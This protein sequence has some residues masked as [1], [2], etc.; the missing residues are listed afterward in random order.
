MTLQ[1]KIDTQAALEDVSFTTGVERYKDAQLRR[2]DREGYERR[3]DVTKLIRGA[4]PILSAAI[5]AWMTHADA[6][7]GRKSPTGSS[8]ASPTSARP[9]ATYSLPR[10]SRFAASPEQSWISGS[11]RASVFGTR[12]SAPPTS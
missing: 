11:E 12:T 8:P 7:K 9:R 5:S 2:A 4:I 6:G 3:D 10:N 1:T